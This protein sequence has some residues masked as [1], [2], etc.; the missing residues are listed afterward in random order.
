MI[1]GK[2]YSTK[3]TKKDSRTY[4]NIRKIATSQGDDY[5]TRCLLNYLYFKDH[6]KL[7]VV[8]F[9]QQQKLDANP[10]AIQQINFTGNRE[11]NARTV[12]IIEEAKKSVRFFK[13]NS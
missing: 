5:T 2:N 4:D 3:Q 6:Y 8:D 10:K 7:I 1:D 9:R 11:N 13:R 12:L